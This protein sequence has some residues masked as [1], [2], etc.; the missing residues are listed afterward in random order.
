LLGRLRGGRIRRRSARS[1]AQSFTITFIA[2]IA[3]AAFLSPLLRSFTVSIKNPDQN[4]QVD[5]PLLPSTAE[6]FTYRGRQFNVY[7]VPFPDG[8]T[9]ELALV[10]KGRTSSQFVDPKDAAQALITWQGEWRTLTPVYAFDPQWHNYADVWDQINYPR[11]LFNTIAIALIGTFGTI[12]SC[13]LVA[14]GFA[15]FRFP[16]RNLL[17]V[18]VIATIFLPGAVTIIPEYFVFSKIG[19]VGTWLPLLV[20]A[21]FAN[22]YDVF[23][24]RQYFLTIPREMD[25]AAAIDGAGPLR[26]LVSVLIPQA[27]PV[28]IAVSVFHLVYS[29]NDF[30]AP[31]IYLS[32]N[33][34]IVT[35]PVGLASFSGA[36]I[37]V[38]PGL[39]QAGTLMTMIIPILLFLAFQRFFTRGIVITGVEK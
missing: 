5:G 9:R 35:L 17:F 7:K 25:E 30:F 36:R 38:N 15:R 20:P 2:V 23:L 31:L 37:S 12:I 1:A 10:R 27:W 21:F 16:G 8:V 13:T 26:T 29:W 24:L 14:Y 3:V 18:M 22:A 39:I 28:I 6:S 19:W 11:L 4:S 33:P 32:T 34:D